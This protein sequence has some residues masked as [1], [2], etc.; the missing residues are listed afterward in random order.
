[1]RAHLLVCLS[2]FTT[3]F[4]SWLAGSRGVAALQRLVRGLP[5]LVLFVLSLRTLPRLVRAL[6]E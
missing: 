2:H 3:A 5:A 4:G 6:Q 1:V